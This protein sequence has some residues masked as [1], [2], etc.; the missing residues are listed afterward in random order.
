MRFPAFLSLLAG[1]L[2]TG[3]AVP[4]GAE[5]VTV[6]S[7]EHRGF[8]RL[9]LAQEIARPWRLG[10]DGKA[11]VLRLDGAAAEFDAGRVFSRIARRRIDAVSAPRPGE[12][13]IDLACD[14]RANAFEE[15]PGLLVIDILDGPPDAQSRFEKALPPLTALAVPTEPLARDDNA[16]YWRNL[17]GERTP[18][19]GTGLEPNIALTLA[20]DE[21]MSRLARAAS[22][23]V[24]DLAGAPG[25]ETATPGSPLLRVQTVMD[26]DLGAGRA[27]GPPSGNACIADERLAVESWAQETPFA[28]QIGPLRQRLLGEFDRPDHAAV[29]ALA[30]FYLHYGMG[31][32]ASALIATF[33]DAVQDR[34]LLSSLAAIV[35][36]TPERAPPRFLSGQASCQGAV[37]LWALLAD[38]APGLLREIARGEI[39][40]H[41]PMLP[42]DLRR[43]IGPELARRFLE[44]G[45]SEAAQ[46]VSAAMARVRTASARP[47]ELLAEA[48][49]EQALGREPPAELAR[50]ALADRPESP[51]AL[52][53][54][55][56][57]QLEEGRPVD[58]GLVMAAGTFAFEMRNDPLG[59]RL[60]RAQVLAL[61][62]TG[63]FEP[64]YAAL[65]GL[66]AAKVLPGLRSELL[67]QLT[68]AASDEGF[69]RY[70]LDPENVPSDLTEGVRRSTAT[71]LLDL[72]FPEE[73][74]R[75]AEGAGTG[76]EDQ[77]LMARAALELGDPQA[78]LRRLVGSAGAEAEAIRARAM[79]SLGNFKGAE[80]AWAAAGNRA[81]ASRA[82]WRAGDRSAVLASGSPEERA[83]IELSRD[84]VEDAAIS[85]AERPVAVTGN[86]PTRAGNLA[87]IRVNE[88]DG[89]QPRSGP[90]ASGRAILAEAKDL[91][92]AIDA[93]LQLHQSPLN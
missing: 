72:G 48:R 66:P 8:T 51:T 50:L 21:L 85:P 20:R 1:L 80:A 56:D 75:M 42:P 45:D 61:G 69:L 84:S 4:A 63:A 7:G 13:R 54:L 83:M 67:G 3:I 19:A 25:E 59:P 93:L 60:I 30:R 79:T 32:E 71:R 29:T 18:A 64:A 24:I 58:P 88:T 86:P 26:R 15:R 57:A 53:M 23:G 28:E 78:A 9:A 49:V 70:A 44:R 5:T 52:L 40:R 62:S 65:E 22:Q 33:P 90:L 36:G 43:Q 41:L 34:L 76:D 91:R 47:G 55:I 2:S 89:S 74:A 46:E 14:C 77:M 16:I 73:A 27:G 92:S 17:L 39:L 11:Y 12:L 37:A 68:A 82:A 31:A 87:A 35:E 6:L 38:P 10:R 81:E